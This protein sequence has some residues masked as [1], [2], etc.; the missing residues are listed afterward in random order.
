MKSVLPPQGAGAGGRSTQERPAG[1]GEEAGALHG[2]EDGPS[3]SGRQHRPYL[4]VVDGGPFRVY[5][6]LLS[7]GLAGAIS[8]T[9]TAPMDRLKMILQVQEDAKG[10]SMRAGIN[11]MAAEGSIRSFFRGNGANV[12]KIAPETAIKLTLNDKLKPLIA[13]DPEHIKPWERMASGGL[14]GAIAQL[15]LYPLDTIRTRLALCHGNK[16]RSIR[17]TFMRI[18]AE[19]GAF[20]LY[21]GLLPNMIGIL[22]YAGVD[23]AI[24]EILKERLLDEYDGA[25]PHLS[26]LMTGMISSTIAQV[27]SYPLA[28]I[29]T[30]LQAQGGTKGQPIK[31][32]GMF[33]VASQTVKREGFRGLYK[34][35]V[36]NLLKLAP[37]AG[38]SWY[39]F[40][41]TKMALGVDPRS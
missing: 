14:S 34:G 29:R 11:K 7:G 24:F 38:I 41:E 23:I 19:E 37:A 1:G 36:P 3:S 10:M 6:L 31:Y 28:L 33:D 18:R 21:R 17:G 2:G 30:R 39:V 32:S 27:V 15:C 12:I 9:A 25:P 13:W 5:K 35:L 16:Y 20:A 4:G 8:R 22:P 26:I 40:E